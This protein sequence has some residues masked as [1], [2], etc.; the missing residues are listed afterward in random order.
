MHNA[1]ALAQQVV[2]GCS[3]ARACA[4]AENTLAWGGAPRE[5]GEA[6]AR[7]RVGTQSFTRGDSCKKR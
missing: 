2:Q 3:Q 4:L 6:H 5:R 7:T 1:A